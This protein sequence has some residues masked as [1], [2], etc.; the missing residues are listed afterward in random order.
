M[1]IFVE[2]SSD[3][4]SIS[5]L[6]VIFNQNILYFLRTTMWQM[7][8]GKVAWQIFRQPLW[9]ICEGMPTM[10]APLATMACLYRGF[11]AFRY[12][13]YCKCTHDAN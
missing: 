1:P 8:N 7:H 5:M 11:S 13:H 10:A 2:K 6:W 12:W 3:T 4:C 9:P